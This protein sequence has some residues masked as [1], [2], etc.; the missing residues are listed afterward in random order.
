MVEDPECGF[1]ITA[2]MIPENQSGILG[3][4]AAAILPKKAP[5]K[6]E[7]RHFAHEP[8]MHL[9]SPSSSMHAVLSRFLIVIILACEIFVNLFIRIFAIKI[10][11][12][13]PPISTLFSK[14]CIIK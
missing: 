3:G 9:F 2:D 1:S 5:C 7:E 14:W 10:H 12:I 11:R 4:T 6:A 13:L 8:V